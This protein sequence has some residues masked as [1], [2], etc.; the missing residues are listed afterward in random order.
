MRNEN[1]VYIN[2]ISNNILLKRALWNVCSIFLFRLFPTRFFC[3]WRILVLRIFGASIN[4]NASVYSTARIESPWNLQMGSNSCIGPHVIL[5]ND[6]II[7]ID[8]N[9]TI[10]QYCYL[11]TSSHDIGSHS[12]DL[13][14]A[15]IVIE[16]DA[17]VAADCYI[18][19][20][21]TIGKG[22]V[23][24]ARSSV[25]KNVEP[26]TVVGGTPAKFIKKRVMKD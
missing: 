26:W 23:V 25:F 5:E 19:K 18:G 22:A 13:I 7:K 16:K 11:C 21:V 1:G 9:A 17:W 12:H 8:E 2:E 20:G 14:T 24:G 10:S 3:K 4:W 6:E 15:P